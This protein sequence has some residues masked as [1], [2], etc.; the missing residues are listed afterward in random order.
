M[1]T[2]RPSYGNLFALATAARAT[3]PSRD[4]HVDDSVHFKHFDSTNPTRALTRK[5]VVD[6]FDRAARVGV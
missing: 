2:I 5:D 6:L 3:H 4:M 1:T